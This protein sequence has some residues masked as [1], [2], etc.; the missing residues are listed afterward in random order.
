MAMEN[1]IVAGLDF[2]RKEAPI[3]TENV[4]IRGIEC[5]TILA[6]VSM[7]CD[8]YRES[9]RGRKRHDDEPFIA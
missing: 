7:I 9:C 5:I 4:L 6:V 8:K 3:L 2:V 1:L